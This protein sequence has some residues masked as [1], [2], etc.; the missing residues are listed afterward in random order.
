MGR[1]VSEGTEEKGV[2]TFN[3]PAQTGQS[4]DDGGWESG[5]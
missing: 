5:G 2:M 3:R 4:N 1:R